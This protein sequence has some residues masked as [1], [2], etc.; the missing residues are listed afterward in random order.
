MIGSGNKTVGSLVAGVTLIEISVFHVDNLNE[1]ITEKK[2]R[3]HLIK[4]NINVQSCFNAK[5]WIK[6]SKSD[7]ISTFRVCITECDK[8]KF[9]NMHIWPESVV[10]CNWKFKSKRN[11]S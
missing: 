2:I 9:F 1:S 11:G 10:I 5:T 3:D 4:N 8:Q 6:N 7:K